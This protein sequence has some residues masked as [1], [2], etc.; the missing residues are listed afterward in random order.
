MRRKTFP[1]E[2]KTIVPVHTKTLLYTHVNWYQIIKMNFKRVKTFKLPLFELNIQCFLDFHCFYISS[3]FFDIYI[4]QR[5]L[6]IKHTAEILPSRKRPKTVDACRRK[7]TINSCSCL[8]CMQ[9]RLQ[10]KGPHTSVLLVVAVYTQHL[11]KKSEHTETYR[12]KST[13][14]KLFSFTIL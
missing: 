6:E 12:G 2:Q 4:R 5:I 14:L 1:S 13:I 9:A 8:E 10:P 11:L 7:Q 3:T